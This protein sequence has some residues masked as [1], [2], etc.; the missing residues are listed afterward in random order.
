MT[1]IKHENINISI[2]LAIPAS[3][4]L[5]LLDLKKNPNMKYA[6]KYIPKNHI[7]NIKLDALKILLNIDAVSCVSSGFFACSLC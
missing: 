5:G 6:I 4:L 1:I 3:L 7:I 2:V